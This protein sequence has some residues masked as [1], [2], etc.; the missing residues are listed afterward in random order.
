MAIKINYCNKKALSITYIISLDLKKL[1][2]LRELTQ[3][4][5]A[6]SKKILTEENLL[7]L[8]VHLAVRCAT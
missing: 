6:N 7:N 4:I 1:L 8:Q 3:M 2:Y 5:I